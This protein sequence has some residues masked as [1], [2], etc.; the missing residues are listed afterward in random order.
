MFDPEVPVS[1][2][3]V[4][5]R[6]QKSVSSGMHFYTSGVVPAS[7]IE[8]LVFSFD[9]RFSLQATDGQRDHARKL[10][11]CTFRLHLFPI[12][13]RSDFAFWLLRNSGNHPL[14]GSERWAD[15]HSDPLLWT[16]WYELRQIPVPAPLREKYVRPGGH[17]AINETTWTWRINREQMDL[18]RWSIRRWVE[19]RDERLPRLIR[20]LS[21]AL[22]R[23]GVRHDVHELYKY[24]SAQRRKR[25]LPSPD[26]PTIYWSTGRR[27]HTVPLSYLISRYRRGCD[28]WFPESMLKRNQTPDLV[29]LDLPHTKE[30][31]H[32]AS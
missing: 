30:K 25:G 12:P 29:P 27:G 23:R 11:R 16:F 28:T 7:K 26:L 6:I 21:F 32:V 17:V 20:S 9:E 3:D 31:T 1:M 13:Q 5:T 14:L 24:I 10:G 15:C 19:Q 22:G 2:S 18:L 8:R 4:M